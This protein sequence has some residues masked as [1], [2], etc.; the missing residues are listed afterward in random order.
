MGAG[1][2][3]FTDPKWTIVILNI[4][5]ICAHAFHEEADPTVNVR[6]AQATALTE[7]GHQVHLVGCE[8]PSEVEDLSGLH[9]YNLISPEIPQNFSD[10]CPTLNWPLTYSQ[11][12]YEACTQLAQQF[13]IDIVDAPLQAAV[14]L[15]T[16][17]YHPGPVVVTVSE[18]PLPD[19][20]DLLDL[21]RLCLQHSAGLVHRAEVTP[22]SLKK[23][24]GFIPALTYFLAATDGLA[25]FYKEVARTYRSR[26]RRAGRVYQLSDAVDYGDGVS[27]IIRRN[28]ALLPQVGGQSIIMA[29]Y[30]HEAVAHEVTIFDPA[31]I[32]G[33]DGLIFHYWGYSELEQFLQSHRGPKAIYYHNI[34]PPEYF[35]PHSRH[36]QMCQEGYQQL[37]RIADQFDLIIGD[38]SYNITGLARFLS[39]SRPMLR[40]P[41]VIETEAVR[42]TP[43]DKSLYQQVRAA[44]PVNF[45][46]VGRIAPNK[47]QD[48]VMQLFD[49]YYR[50]INNHSYLYLVGNYEHTPEYFR[51]LIGLHQKLAA[52]ERI[53]FPGKVSDEAVQAYYRAADVFISASEHEGFGMPLLEAMAHKLPVMALASSAIPETMGKAG[54]LVH[55]WDVPRLAELINLLLK[56][57]QWHNN[58][59]TGQRQNLSR[60]SAIEV[61]HRLGLAVNYLREGDK[62]PL[63]SV[64]E[65]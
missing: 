21:Q 65:V 46:F 39:N 6:L 22:A 51:Q 2:Y 32:R 59:L 27:N 10:S 36:Y 63:L 40:I 23:R 12:V 28:A 7:Q 34:T 43:F 25:A 16:A 54:L 24:Y 20:Q 33:D 57:K 45:L 62:E 38:S 64:A 13:P 29:K 14:G 53:V 35:S 31:Y 11:L 44:A 48:R 18:P 3:I 55:R 8:I 56:D 1:S 9:L 30:A 42:A 52:R 47:R 60:F 37:A 19:R 50:Q 58:L 15:I 26:P 41:P 17:L 4:C 49:Y 5:L 61:Q